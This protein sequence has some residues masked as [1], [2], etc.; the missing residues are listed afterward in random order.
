MNRRY[1]IGVLYYGAVDYEHTLCMRAIERHPAV[2]RVVEVTACPYI[3]IGRST[4]VARLAEFPEASGIIFIDHDILFDAEAITLLAES[5]DETESVVGAI[6]SMRKPGSRTI[7]QVDVAAS[8]ARGQDRI[9]YLN[10]GGLYPAHY[11]GM[12]FTGIHRKVFES[13]DRE[14]PL[15]KNSV[16]GVDIR[17]YFAL[18]VDAERGVYLGEDVSFCERAQRAGHGV[19]ADTRLRVFH[20]GSY[21]YALE[22]CGV[23][24]PLLKSIEGVAKTDES[25]PIASNVSPH[26]EVLRAMA[27]RSGQDASSDLET[28]TPPFPE[29]TSI[30]ELV[31]CSSDPCAG[32]GN[33]ERA[34]TALAS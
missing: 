22:D 34:P 27:E 13:L 18:T 23:V 16:T 29:T 21:S 26:P 2:I 33:D 3:C 8:K 28:S 14:L 6:Y 4:V 9:I 7:G 30:D 24:V 10:G 12:G 15:V 19:Y 17:P 25:Q 31:P 32:R 1:L 11:L 20:K 5:L